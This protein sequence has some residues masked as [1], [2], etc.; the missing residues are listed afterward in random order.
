MIR[1]DLPEAYEEF[2]FSLITESRSLDLRA[3]DLETRKDWEKYF[4][5]RFL[6]N[7]TTN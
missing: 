3:N 5:I 4:K 2:C 6:Q 1:Y 7:R